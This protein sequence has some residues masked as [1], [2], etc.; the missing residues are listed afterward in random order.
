[1]S[2]TCFLVILIKCIIKIEGYTKNYWHSEDYI[3]N[4]ITNLVAAGSH[5]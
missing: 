5:L 4:L 1:M 3:K 2:E